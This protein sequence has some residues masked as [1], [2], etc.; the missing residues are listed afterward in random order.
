M[1]VY[2]EEKLRSS[3]KFEALISDA[4]E[5]FQRVAAKRGYIP[6]QRREHNACIPI[7]DMPLNFSLPE[8][9]RVVSLAEEYDL[10]KYNR[11]LWR[12]FN[13]PG[14]PPETPEM[15]ESRRIELSGPDADRSLKIAVAAPDG[16]FVSYCGMW[17]LPGDEYALVEPVATDPDYRRMGLGRAAVLEGV[18]RCGKRGAKKAYVGSSQQFYYAIGFCPCGTDTW[19]ERRK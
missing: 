14:D 4:D 18:R 1:L 10:K 17:H 16:N 5:E 3:E 2:A 9:F 13:H 6:T 15:L 8:G 11:V 12:G 7:G 19:W